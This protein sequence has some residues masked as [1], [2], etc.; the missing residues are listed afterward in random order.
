MACF[1]ISSIIFCIATSCSLAGP[2]FTSSPTLPSTLPSAMPAAGTGGDGRGHGVAASQGGG[3][4]PSDAGRTRQSEMACRQAVGHQAAGRGVYAASIRREGGMGGGF[5]HPPAPSCNPSL[6]AATTPHPQRRPHAPRPLT[7]ADPDQ[8]REA[9]PERLGG[10]RRGGMVAGRR[11]GVARLRR[12]L[13]RLRLCSR[14]GRLRKRE[15]VV[16]KTD[17]RAQ[18]EP[19]SSNAVC[20]CYRN[21]RSSTHLHRGS[22]EVGR[23]GRRQQGRGGHGDPA[24]LG[25]HC[26]I[27]SFHARV[28]RLRGRPGASPI[29]CADGAAPRDRSD[30]APGQRAAVRTHPR[31]RCA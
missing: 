11:H 8:G 18:P 26:S 20:T 7:H 2:P 3:R 16:I 1:I 31:W 25:G 21:P 22:L 30:R 12:L 6:P 27:G 13:R 9:A 10:R 14:G 17:C 19:C 15:G 23:N 29:S 4:R 5:T 24:A 28:R